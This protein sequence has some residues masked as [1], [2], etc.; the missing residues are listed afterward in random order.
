MKRKQIVG[1]AGKGPS[2]TYLRMAG[3]H[4]WE[5]ALSSPD[6]RGMG[7]QGSHPRTPDPDL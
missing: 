3:P 7:H 6:T 4:I 5:Q 1:P 2:G